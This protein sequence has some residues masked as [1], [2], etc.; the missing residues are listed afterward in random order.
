MIYDSGLRALRYLSLPTSR[1][2]TVQCQIPRLQMFVFRSSPP[3]FSDKRLSCFRFS[4]DPGPAFHHDAPLEDLSMQCRDRK[5]PGQWPG[6]G[7]RRRSEEIVLQHHNGTTAGGRDGSNAD[8]S[9]L[10]LRRGSSLHRRSSYVVAIWPRVA[11]GKSCH[12]K[13]PRSIERLGR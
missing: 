1:I 4:T 6:L 13:N 11:R 12:L 2:Y 7:G 9:I 5:Q 3:R 8:R 10:K